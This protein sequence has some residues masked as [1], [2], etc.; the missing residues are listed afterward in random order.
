MGCSHT[1]ESA[2]TP[3]ATPLPQRVYPTEPADIGRSVDSALTV[4]TGAT[5]YPITSAPIERGYVVMEAGNIVEVG[6]GEAPR[7]DNAAYVDASGTFITPGVIDTHSHMGVYANP[8]VSAHS[9]GNEMVGPVT[10]DVWA[11]HGFWPQDP[12]IRRALSGGVT[13]IQVL[14]GSAN[15]IGGRSYIAK[16][17]PGISAREMRF[18]GA[19]QG[20]KMAC[21]EN[22]KRVY[23]S[24]GGPRTRMG[25]V[26]GYRR[27]FQQARNY[28]YSQQAYERDLA[29]WK[30]EKEANPEH[31]EDPPS[32]PG[33][34]LEMETL[35]K[36]LNGEILVHNHCYRADEMHI[37]LDLA[38]EFGFKI[39]SFHH[40]LEAY[41]LK[42]RLAK[43]DVASST[44]AD[45]WGFKMEAYDGIPHNA[46][47]LSAAGAKAVIHSDS[48]TDIRRL[49]QEAAKARRAGLDL[50]LE[51]SETEALRWITLNAAW[52]LGIDKEV[53]SLEK[54][55]HADIVV[56][57][58]HPLSVYSKPSKVFIDGKLLFDRTKPE[59][60]SD[61]EI[62]Q[63]HI[64]HKMESSH[65]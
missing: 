16:L 39:R 60:L 24:R 6:T 8:S 1:E 28:L 44:W 52:A 2:S 58:K 57:D 18:P 49:N 23:G 54:G 56:W 48:S 27:S 29:A 61:F 25:N 7:F 10:A 33:R 63:P 62:G 5:L 20:L 41:K 55:K 17:K 26:A 19:P 15:L 59:R 65:D 30:K 21:G 53:G 47:L 40:A 43:E 3:K 12:S 13:T 50:G 42:D 51:I 45:W 34:D 64:D 32:L 37:M 35:A 22:P 14:P 38:Q 4:L 11:E 36:V 46:A 9:D 31:D